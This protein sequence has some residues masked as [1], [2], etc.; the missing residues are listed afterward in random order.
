MDAVVICELCNM[1]MKNFLYNIAGANLC[2]NAWKVHDF[3]F[4][5]K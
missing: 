4:L 3:S 1:Y 5:K 2:E